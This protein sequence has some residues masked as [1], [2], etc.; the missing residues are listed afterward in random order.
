M[1]QQS[2]NSSSTQVHKDSHNPDYLKHRA[3]EA[4]NLLQHPLL[5]EFFQIMEDKYRNLLWELPPDDTE[6]MRKVKENI[7][8]YKTF[9]GFFESIVRTGKIVSAYSTKKMGAEGDE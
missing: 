9:K 6:S 7:A 8:Y 5:Q 2:S 4:S 1:S 3:E